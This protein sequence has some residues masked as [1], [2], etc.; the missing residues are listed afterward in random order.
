[1]DDSTVHFS[2]AHDSPGPTDTMFLDIRDLSST[3]LVSFEPTVIG[4]VNQSGIGDRDVLFATAVADGSNRIGGINQ[5]RADLVLHDYGGRLV[6]AD[7]PLDG[8]YETHLQTNIL[9]SPILHHH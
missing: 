2:S 9:I 6:S 5:I 7:L 8:Q 3:S 4:V 1:M